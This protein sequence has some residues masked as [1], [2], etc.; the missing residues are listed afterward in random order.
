MPESFIH[1]HTHS[2]YS[3]AEGAIQT[4]DLVKLCAK[5]GM[6]ALAVTDTNNMF[7]ALEF[8]MEAQKGGI[9][10][11]IGTQ[12]SVG[13]EGHQLV[14]LAQTE[15]GYRNLCLLIS[16]AY[17]QGDPQVNVHLDREKLRAHSKGLICLTGGA[18][19]AAAQFLVHGQK[20]QADAEISELKKIF[21]DRLY[22][23]LQRHGLAEEDL[24]EG[25]LIEL[26]YKH[27]IPL[28]A[29]NDCY[30]SEPDIYEAHDA[31]LCIADGRYVT[32]E[33]RR[34]V[35][36]EHYFKSA[37]E[38]IELFK[39]VPEAIDNTVVI[40]QRCSYLLQAISPI[41]PAF[42]TEGGRSEFEEL[43]AQAEEGLEWR[44]KN[45]VTG[46]AEPYR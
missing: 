12:M 10:P 15:E 36:P 20:E 9:Q 18:K 41:L 6:P 25:G 14:L 44:L 30:F 27:D 21:K 39:D 29:T 40:A 3:L 38:M 45:F 46:E 7:G 17:L 13:S 16:D 31:L 37:D 35:T 1:L 22:V 4:K 5:E 32:E 24:S 28:V 11:I 34:K 19:G 26:A 23:E 8:A 33:N 43:A 42:E 2:A